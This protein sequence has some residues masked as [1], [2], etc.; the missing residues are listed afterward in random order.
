[1]KVIIRPHYGKRNGRYYVV[2]AR[3]GKM[4]NILG[5][6]KTLPEA[7]AKKQ[8]FLADMARYN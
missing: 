6:Y 5:R 7:K 4:V 1:M 8:A 3:H 2:H